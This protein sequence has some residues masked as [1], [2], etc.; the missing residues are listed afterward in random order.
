MNRVFV[1]ALYW[2]AV[3]NPRDQ[4]HNRAAAVGNS[5][6]GRGLVTTESVLAE[7]LNYFGEYGKMFRVRTARLVLALLARDD[8]EVV[9]Q[10][11]QAFLDGVALYR[12][13]PDKG[14]SLTDC[15]S[16]NVMRERDMTEVL[17]HDN[18]FTQEGFTI[19]L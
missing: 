4:W 10:S 18:H 19:L 16:M 11:R 13:R 8:V 5:V 3:I 7:V 6:E 12:A 1:D 2:V 17:T 15:I 9:E 14:Y